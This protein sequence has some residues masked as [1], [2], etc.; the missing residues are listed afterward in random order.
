MGIWLHGAEDGEIS[1]PDGIGKYGTTVDVGSPE[2][3]SAVNG[4]A[5]VWE[6]PGRAPSRTPNTTRNSARR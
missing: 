2:L 5:D 4:E 6:E 1:I 3:T